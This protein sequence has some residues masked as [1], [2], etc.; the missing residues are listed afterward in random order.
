MKSILLI[1][2]TI[3]SCNI[4]LGQ[5][6][7][8][9]ANMD[10]ICTSAGVSFTANVD[11]GTAEP[12]NNYD[13]LQTQP[14]PSWYYFEIATNGNIDMS[15][16]ALLDIDFIIW[17]PFANLAAAQADCG[18]MGQTGS[19]P[20]VDCSYDPTNNETPSIPSTM[21][22][23][24]Y[25]LLITNYANTVQS[26][27]LTQT[28]GTGSTDCS[29]LPPCNVDIGSFTLKK[30]EQI[31]TGP[32]LI[33][34]G[35][36]F[37]VISNGNYILPADTIPGPQGDDVY[38]AQLMFL[39][40]N[41]APTG[42][43]P[44][45]DPG[46]TN[47]IIPSDSLYEIYDAQSQ[48]ITALGCGTYYL[49]PVTG[50]DGIGENNN[51]VGT[52]DNGIIHWDTDGNGC[53]VLGTAIEVT[54]VCPIGPSPTVNCT[55]LDNGLDFN[56][57]NAGTYTLTN[58]AQGDLVSNSVVFPAP[59]QLSNLSHNDLYLLKVEDQNGCIDTVTGNFITPL[60][61]NV[62]II[63]A[64][65]CPSSG[66]GMVVVQGVPNSGNGGLAQII[67]NGI[68]ETTT[69]P[70]DT[71]SALAGTLVNIQL[72]DQNGCHNDSSVTVNSIGH[73]ITINVLNKTTVS[74]F[75]DTDGTATIEAFGV[76]G[77][78][79]PDNIAIQTIVWT[80]PSGATSPGGSTNTNLT[81]MQAGIW[82]ITVVDVLG[83]SNTISFEIISPQS[84]S[85]SL[86]LNNPQCF[87]VDNGSITA[88]TNGGTAPFVFEIKDNLGNILN[89]I[90]TNTANTLGDGNYTANVVDANG[91]TSNISG[92]LI[93]PPA[94]D[95]SFS[96]KKVSCFG[97]STGVLSVLEVYNNT[98][99][100]YYQWDAPGIGGFPNSSTI[101]NL[102]AGDY[103]L[104]IGDAI[105]CTAS[106]DF[107]I[108][109]NPLLIDS[110]DFS[111]SYCRTK[112][113]QSG[114]G[115]ITVFAVGGVGP[116][117]YEWKNNQTN[118]TNINTTWGGLNPGTYTATTVDNA[119]CILVSTITLDS[120]N[121]I[122]DFEAISPQFLD[123]N[124][125]E[126]T[127]IMQIE[128]EN[129]SKNYFDSQNP[130]S[131]TTFKWNLD[132]N[133]VGG[134][135]W[136][137]RYDLVNVDTTYG[138]VLNPV[139]QDYEVCLVATNFNGCYDTLCKTI[140]VFA[141]PSLV[142]PNVFTPGK[143]P[144]STFFF[145]SRGID[146]KDVDAFDCSVFDRY[147]V[148]V[149]HFYSI[150]DQWNGNNMRNDN[151][152]KDGVYFYTYTAKSSDGTSFKGQG[153]IHLFNSSK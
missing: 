75:G 78:Q 71:L 137:F 66:L 11:V 46:F 64:S 98:G 141:K 119:G 101:Q 118:E 50:D 115:V 19:A 111:P 53:F 130:F 6:N 138:V 55:T 29:I 96:V 108:T 54:F 134:G 10:P 95:G 145:P 133:G 17:G 136:F 97:D 16:T 5:N 67:M 70:N 44:S 36:N 107:T 140:T 45:I 149:F 127:E 14:N 103:S 60:F 85:M 18:V 39:V 82:N 94:I 110:L 62:T 42:T 151:L 33:C 48:I 21:V 89:A 124:V 51:V 80:S 68:I 129:N 20:V 9:C 22:G 23:E 87:D 43:D 93:N 132:T 63:P 8:T 26:I 106:F 90:G 83:C 40:Y 37:E 56:F 47:L 104:V 59:G 150:D 121:P 65:D 31:T 139:A 112:N 57:A 152:C 13:C 2:V 147:G 153:Q 114:N 113:F 24:V 143:D 76:D 105:G 84:L 58:L 61:N 126:G 3:I 1:F 131:D 38:S 49:V 41:A 100:V 52:N 77:S 128:F 72:I 125:L 25:V 120:L 7:S 35:D 12:G 34:E 135:N 99:L 74:C 144:N 27:S 146:G 69:L 28:G 91:C 32:L 142:T 148:E 116:Y 122:A 117:Q 109:Q 73:S 123:P 79:V 88:F 4:G 86:N 92:T 81:G 15:L 30:N 102:P